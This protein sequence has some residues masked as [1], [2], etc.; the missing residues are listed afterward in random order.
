MDTQKTKHIYNTFDWTDVHG[1]ILETFNSENKNEKDDQHSYFKT[2]DERTEQKVSFDNTLCKT[3]HKSR[4]KTEIP[5]N[6]ASDFSVWS[7]GRDASDNFKDN[8][9]SS[10]PCCHGHGET[11]SSLAQDCSGLDLAEDSPDIYRQNFVD[12]CNA[13]YPNAARNTSHG[14]HEIANFVESDGDHSNVTLV[15]KDVIAD[16]VV[17]NG[18]VVDVGR[19][20]VSHD[21]ISIEPMPKKD[22]TQPEN[23]ADS[24]DSRRNCDEGRYASN[25]NNEKSSTVSMNRYC[26]NE[27]CLEDPLF[28]ADNLKKYDDGDVSAA[29][30]IDDDKKDED[31]NKYQHSLARDYTDRTSTKVESTEIPANEELKPLFYD[32]SNE[33]Q[34]DIIVLH[35]N[36]KLRIV[37]K[38]S[39]SQNMRFCFGGKFHPRE[40]KLK[41]TLS[42]C[43]QSVQ[44]HVD[45]I[46]FSELGIDKKDFNFKLGSLA[47][48][49]DDN[50]NP[51]KQRLGLRWIFQYGFVSQGSVLRLQQLL[52][53]QLYPF[54][55]IKEFWT[56]LGTDSPPSLQECMSVEWMRYHSFHNYPISAY[57]STSRLARD[58]FYYTGQGIQTR[59][60]SCGITHNDWN[61]TD[62][63]REVHQ[64]LS[65]NCPFLNGREERYPNIPM[66]PDGNVDVGRADSDS[67]P[68][69]SLPTAPLSGSGMGQSLAER[70]SES[71][72]RSGATIDKD[73]S[74]RQNLGSGET[75]PGVSSHPTE[76]AAQSEADN[77]LKYPEHDSLPS[78]IGSFSH[79]WPPYLDQTPQQMAEAG[80]FYTGNQD[81]TRC[82]HCGGGLR[83]WEP[84]DNPWIEH[85][86]WYPTCPHVLKGKGQRFVHAVLKKH[87]ELLAKQQADCKRKAQYDL[88]ELKEENKRLKNLMT[89]KICLDNP[90]R[91]VFI[92]CGHFVCE[93]CAPAFRKCPMCR[94]RIQTSV[95]AIF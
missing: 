53:H 89:C 6:I 72:K 88:G 66:S 55:N 68:L 63:P 5:G 85:C 17:L 65:P 76:E 51:F 33:P 12:F 79:G 58:G 52:I 29:A 7:C 9:D 42:D 54:T 95:R 37:Q 34:S 45:G 23:F 94:K 64:R 3:C 47:R 81:Y 44:Q 78:R 22:K 83:N 93:T 10:D 25:E 4:I 61:G 20:T 32:Y 26:D 14:T 16:N 62:N 84:G 38:M 21:P 41:L 48:E 28:T 2:D 70:R 13:N 90:V 82:Y 77:R 40:S 50:E 8:N 73:S 24:S 35:L 71:S 18:T 67:I 30:D 87:A 27:N 92:P 59:C 56:S 75:T 43:S 15:A 46:R 11:T 69:P 39:F 57:G 91:V 80:F 31:V 36:S 1:E 86:R 74:I 60:F 19:Y 49:S